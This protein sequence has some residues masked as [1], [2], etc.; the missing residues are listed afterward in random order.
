M[1]K[2]RAEAATATP[3]TRAD[4][5][6]NGDAARCGF[7]CREAALG[8][9]VGKRGYLRDVVGVQDTVGPSVGRA[10]APAISC[11]RLHHMHTLSGRNYSRDADDYATSI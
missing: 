10:N 7:R 5:L 8:R 1:E 6:R 9:L 11:T 2:S 3:A 4:L